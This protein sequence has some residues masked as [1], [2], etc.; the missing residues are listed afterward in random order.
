[1]INFIQFNYGHNH[2]RGEH[3]SH[4]RPGIET[5]DDPEAIVSESVVAD[6]VPALDG[7]SEPVR[8]RVILS[9]KRLVLAES[10]TRT[11]IPLRRIFDVRIGRV[12]GELAH[13]LSEGLT[14]AYEREGARRVAVVASDDGTIERFAT[15]LFKTLVNGT[16]ATIVHPARVGRRVTGVAPRDVTLR[17]RPEAVSFQ[18]TGNPVRISFAAVTHFEKHSREIRERSRPVLSVRHTDDGTATTTEI[19]LASGRTANLLGRYLRRE[20][21]AVANET[22]SVDLSSAQ[23]QTLVVLHSAPEGVDLA[24][25]LGAE[26]SAVEGVLDELREKGLVADTGRKVRLTSRGRS[27]VDA[28]LR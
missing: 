25:L 22:E 20:C 13:A 24:R 19:I 7:R 11:T 16:S 23:T 5:H 21:G 6:F 14:V 12:P 2:R 15:V 26:P 9:R 1:M 3:A 17:L 27:V 18:G 10:D 8:G 28:L 4:E